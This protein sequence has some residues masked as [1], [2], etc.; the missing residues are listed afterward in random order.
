MEGKEA[1]E[2]DEQSLDGETAN[3]SRTGDSM[4]DNAS[5][6]GLDLPSSDGLDYDQVTTWNMTQVGLW[7]TDAGLGKYTQAFIDKNIVGSVLLELDGAKL[8]VRV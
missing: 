2:D 8:K 7:L 5:T 3:I 4:A 6:D 1:E